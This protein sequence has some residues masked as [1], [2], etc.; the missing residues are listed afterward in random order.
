MPPGSLMQYRSKT[1]SPPCSQ[2]GCGQNQST[3]LF[4]FFPKDVFCV[5]S[6]VQI[7][8]LFSLVIWCCEPNTKKRYHTMNDSWVNELEDGLAWLGSS[9]KWQHEC[10]V[11]VYM[12]FR[13]HFHCVQ[14]QEAIHLEGDVHVYTKHMLTCL[15]QNFMPTS[16][17][18]LRK[19]QGITKIT[20]KVLMAIHP[21]I[22]EL[23]HSGLLWWTDQPTVTS[24]L[25]VFLFLPVFFRLDQRLRLRAL[26]AFWGSAMEIEMTQPPSLFRDFS[27][28]YPTNGGMFELGLAAKMSSVRSHF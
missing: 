8:V 18:S 4:F 6:S 10:K 11:A 26:A 23:F 28:K 2:M 21:I 5:C 14:C 17:W 20:T 12:T 15:N 3:H 9:S 19:S 24:C 16:W 25:S 27:D 7:S 13:L 1:S 22:V